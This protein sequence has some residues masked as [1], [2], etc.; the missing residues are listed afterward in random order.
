YA[1][2]IRSFLGWAFG[3]ALLPVDLRATVLA[4]RRF[5]QAGIRDVLSESDVTQI[6][7][8]VDRSSATGRR[9]YAVLLLAARYGLLPAAIRRL[10]V[11]ALQWRQGMLSIQ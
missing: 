7:A 9:D 1:V 11:E 8:A 3:A 5:R 4:P 2:T 6:L 10:T